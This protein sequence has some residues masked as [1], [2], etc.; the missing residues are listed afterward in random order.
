MYVCVHICVCLYMHELCMWGCVCACVCV[1]ICKHACI[2]VCVHVCTCISVCLCVCLCMCISACVCGPV[3]VFPCVC[4]HECVCGDVHVCCVCTELV[5]QVLWTL[6]PSVRYG[7]VFWLSPAAESS[8]VWRR[9]NRSF[10]RC[11]AF[12][13]WG[14]YFVE[15]VWPQD[16]LC[17]R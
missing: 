16:T 6:S 3:G 14:F 4:M 15:S 17:H 5:K 11:L 9:S 2:S 10:C 7:S 8:F 12:M 13:S 1:C